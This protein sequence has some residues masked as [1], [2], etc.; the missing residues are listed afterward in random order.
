MNQ[1][2]AGYANF[3]V[4]VESL[5][6]IIDAN[7]GNVDEVRDQ[8]LRKAQ[9]VFSE[10]VDKVINSKMGLEYATPEMAKDADELWEEIEPI[11][12]TARADWTLFWRQVTY[13]AT[14]FS[15]AKKSYDEPASPDDLERMLTILLGAENTNPFYDPLTDEHREALLSWLGKWHKCL[16]CSHRNPMS[17]SNAD[18]ILPPEER[19]RNANPKYTLREWMLVDAYTKANGSKFVP[20]DYSL[21][22]ELYELCKDPYGEGTQEFHDKY[23]RRAPDESLRAGG[24]AFMS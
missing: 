10:A 19:M 17:M 3:A 1:P 18:S 7:G 12:R 4:L 20:G 23:Y 15:P 11:L 5:L 16:V 9:T 21:V 13:V 14:E 8:M 22:H 24:T 2:K 6:P